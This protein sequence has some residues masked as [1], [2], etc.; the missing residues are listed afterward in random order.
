MK[1]STALN[2]RVSLDV[3]T[4]MS[5]Q[6]KGTNVSMDGYVVHQ[7]MTAM[8]ATNSPKT[9]EPRSNRMPRIFRT[10]CEPSVGA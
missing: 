8:S 2:A 10:N 7:A 4:T 5:V 3:H 9:P 6:A 1:V